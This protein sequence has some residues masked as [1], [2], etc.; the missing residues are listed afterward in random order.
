MRRLVVLVSRDLHRQL[1]LASVF[2]EVPMAAIVR[3][4]IAKEIETEG[5]VAKREAS[6]EC[7]R[8]TSIFPGR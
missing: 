3:S 1:K 7:R 6:D 2:R 5:G 4:A 8:G